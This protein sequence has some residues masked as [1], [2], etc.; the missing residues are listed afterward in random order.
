VLIFVGR[1][2]ANHPTE[3]NKISLYDVEKKTSAMVGAGLQ[4]PL[5]N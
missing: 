5:K 1:V 2:C 4:G 3:T